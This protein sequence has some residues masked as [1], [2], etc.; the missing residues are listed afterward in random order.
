MLI[1]FDHTYLLN[2]Y[3]FNVRLKYLTCD[4]T[5]YKTKHRSLTNAKKQKSKYTSSHCHEKIVLFWFFQ[6]LTLSL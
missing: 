6:A 3:A 4:V 2:C 1:S 5:N